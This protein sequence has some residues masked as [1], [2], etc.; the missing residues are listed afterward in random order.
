PYMQQPLH[1]DVSQVRAVVADRAWPHDGRHVQL[2]I[3]PGDIRDEHLRGVEDHFAARDRLAPSS[4]LVGRRKTAPRLKHRHR[5]RTEPA[6]PAAK[7]VDAD[8]KVLL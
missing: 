8:M 5:I 1:R 7:I 3:E 6:S 2:V 4:E